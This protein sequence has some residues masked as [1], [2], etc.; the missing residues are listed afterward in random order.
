MPSEDRIYDKFEA[1]WYT[2]LPVIERRGKEEYRQYRNKVTELSPS[3]D[4]S[5]AVVEEHSTTVTSSG[6]AYL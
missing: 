6:L 2:I 1:V 5:I 4:F 3:A